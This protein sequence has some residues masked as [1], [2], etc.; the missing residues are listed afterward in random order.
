MIRLPPSPP[1]PLLL[2]PGPPPWPSS[3]ASWSWLWSWGPWDPPPDPGA[4]R[5]AR[6]H[7]AG[8]TGCDE[9]QVAA[10]GRHRLVRIAGAEHGGR[11]CCDDHLVIALRQTG[12]A[13]ARPDERAGLARWQGRWQPAVVVEGNDAAV[14][15]AQGDRGG[16]LCGDSGIRRGV[17]R[18]RDR[19]M[20]RSQYRDA[21]QVELLPGG[22]ATDGG[23]VRQ[24]N[25]TACCYAARCLR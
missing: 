25:I 11:A 4:R 23:D 6:D 5:A 14:L 8:P 16:E 12:E 22:C 10:A 7:G 3:E 13:A 17:K 9:G 2:P 18:Q 21:W 19:L 15:D 1:R 20:V 24:E